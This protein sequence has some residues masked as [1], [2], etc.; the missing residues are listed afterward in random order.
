MFA[1]VAIIAGFAAGVMYVWVWCE[2]DVG[3]ICFWY[4]IAGMGRRS[5]QRCL[6][7]SKRLQ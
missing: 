2:E 6:V 5:G 7:G 4:S 3:K 1:D